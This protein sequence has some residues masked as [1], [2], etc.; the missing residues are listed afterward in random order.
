MARSLFTAEYEVLTAA[1]IAARKTAGLTQQELA[2]KL[3]RPQSYVAKYEGMQRRLDVVELLEI[4]SALRCDPHD[5]IEAV[6]KA[7]RT[8]KK[9]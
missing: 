7:Q 1:L 5:I 6:R 4:T 8:A 2:D 3:D 9:T